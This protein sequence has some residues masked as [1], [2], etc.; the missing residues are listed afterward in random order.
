M[1]SGWNDKNGSSLI[2]YFFPITSRLKITFW[3]KLNRNRSTEGQNP[4]QQMKQ[5]ILEN[6]RF[7]FQ[8]FPIGCRKGFSYILLAEYNSL[9]C[10]L[11][12]H[13]NNIFS[14]FYKETKYISS[15]DF[16]PTNHAAD[17]EW[18][19]LLKHKAENRANNLFVNL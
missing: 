13:P 3:S 7:K 19:K 17:L 14:T 4:F 11:I 16:S 12:N 9:W 2:L 1:N 8:N 6:F 15:Q 5:E 18:L 10:E